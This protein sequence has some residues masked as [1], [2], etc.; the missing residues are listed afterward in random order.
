MHPLL[1]K[2]VAEL[3]ARLQGRAGAGITGLQ[4]VAPMSW[5]AGAPLWPVGIT[6]SQPARVMAILNI[7]PD[8]FSERSSS[9]ALMQ[10]RAAV[11]RAQQLVR[12]G[13][14]VLDLG[15][16]SSRPGATVLSAQDE[17]ARLRPVLLAVRA[18]LP[19]VLISVDT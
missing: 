1:G 18:A 2:S 12:A 4:R 11:A 3:L 16:Q 8:S 6:G 10:P 15:A 17:L 13:A 9:S 7:T 19:A 5:R 14:A